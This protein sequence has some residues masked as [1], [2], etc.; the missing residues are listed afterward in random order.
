[1]NIFVENN[2][3]IIEDDFLVAMMLQDILT[4]IGWNVC[5]TAMSEDDAVEAAIAHRPILV[6][7]DY[8]LK[9][10]DGVSASR[11]IQSVMD[12]PVLYVSGSRG[13]VEQRAPMAICVDK[14]FTLESIE[15]GIAAV[16]ASGS[17]LCDG[18]MGGGLQA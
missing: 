10:G 11:R 8:K 14:P 15:R 12:V 13:E 6:V 18:H 9:V 16:L 2:A 17:S 7:S 1:M 5:H 3:L 4:T